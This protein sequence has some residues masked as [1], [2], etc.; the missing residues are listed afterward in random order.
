MTDPILMSLFPSIAAIREIPQNGYHHLNV[1]GHTLAVVSR[2]F[3]LNELTARLHSP[4]LTLSD[5]DR[6][7]LRLAALFH[8]VGKAGTLQWNENGITTFKKHQFRS[9]DLFLTDIAR[10][11]PS[12]RL[13]E[14]VYMLIRRHML[15]LNFML[16]GWSEKSFR[17]LINMMREDSRLL[18]LLALADKLSAEGPLSAG[19][20]DQMAEIGTAFMKSYEKEA[21]TIIRLPKLV[22]GE[23]VMNVLGLSPSP[24]VGKVLGIIADRQLADPAFDREQAL[25]ILKEY[26]NKQ[27]DILH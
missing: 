1:L 10:L 22:S 17:K 21:E 24:E 23:E 19:S 4:G 9:A 16:N 2:S 8:D 27:K 26:R 12:N 11:K 7:V 20:A 3:R 5:E 6:I 14:R 15:F 25:I 18:A 13:M